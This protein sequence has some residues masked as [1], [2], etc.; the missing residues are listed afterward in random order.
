MTFCKA[1]L[2][3][4]FKQTLFFN[5]IQ[6]NLPCRTCLLYFVLI[7]FV[8]KMHETYVTWSNINQTNIHFSLHLVSNAVSTTVLYSI[9]TIVTHHVTIFLQLHT[10]QS[11]FKLCFVFV[12]C[13][14][15][16]YSCCSCCY[17]VKL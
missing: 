7:L 3:A 15:F 2:F 16:Y 8:M 14:L 10:E 13:Y 4:C 6:V 5:S 12:F 11:I 9:L 1:N 17:N